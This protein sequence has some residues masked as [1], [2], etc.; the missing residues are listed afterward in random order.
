VAVKEA[1]KRGLLNLRNS[2]DAFGESL[3]P[4]VIKAFEQ[5]GV[6]SAR[7]EGTTRSLSSSTTRPSTSR[8]AD[9][10]MAGAFCRRR[11]ASRARSRRRWRGQGGSGT[12]RRK[13]A[14]RGEQARGRVPHRTIALQKLLEHEGNGDPGK[15][16]KY[17]RD[18]VIPAMEALRDAGDAL[19][20]S[21]RR[22]CGRCRPI[23]NAVRMTR[24]D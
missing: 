19:K 13:S 17:F 20:P 4:D 6:L 1:S 8:R 2:V 7:A 9:G 22:I 15:H 24:Q 11:T 14:R 12:G 5:Y 18:K 10:P 16:A 23:A 3:K 21:S